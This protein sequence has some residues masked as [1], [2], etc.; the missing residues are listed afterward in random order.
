MGTTLLL[1]VRPVF[2][3]NATFAFHH[4]LVPFE[5]WSQT[6]DA[7]HFHVGDRNGVCIPQPDEHNEPQM[8]TTRKPCA[9]GGGYSPIPPSP[10]R[11]FYDLF[12]AFFT[13]SAKT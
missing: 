1:L 11:V 7:S 8:Q 13:S 3:T 10:H 5:G 12:Y 4:Q 2:E 6:G 9:N